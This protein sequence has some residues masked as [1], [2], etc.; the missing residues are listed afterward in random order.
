MSLD[1]LSLVV[2][3]SLKDLY[4]LFQEAEFEDVNER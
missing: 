3:K 1:E 2:V 4:F